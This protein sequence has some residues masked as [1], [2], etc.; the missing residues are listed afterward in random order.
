MKIF[1]HGNLKSI[2][3]EPIS[4]KISPINIK[5]N[6]W[7]TIYRGLESL[8]PDFRSKFKESNQYNIVA[9]TGD[10]IRHLSEQDLDFPI[11]ADELHIVPNID[12]S[13]VELLVL[14]ATLGTQYALVTGAI[15]VMQAALI[16]IAVGFIANALAPKPKLGGGINSAEKKD[17][18]YFN[19]ATNVTEP[20]GAIPLVYGRCLVGS[21]VASV[22]L[23]TIDLYTP[24]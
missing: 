19:G 3:P 13:G 8:L 2:S 12:G 14:A 6:N 17:S 24:A 21:V 20:G 4:D 5:S 11:Q 23:E 10:N 1:L 18:F 7:A 16:S 9:K 15:T 22:G